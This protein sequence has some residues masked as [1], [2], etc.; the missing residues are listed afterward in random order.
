MG[1]SLPP[2]YFPLT[3]LLSIHIQILLIL[4]ALL[5]PLLQLT[6]LLF[7]QPQPLPQPH[8]FLIRLTLRRPHRLQLLF[9]RRHFGIAVALL[10]H[11]RIPP[12][13][14][15]RLIFRHGRQTGL[16]P[17]AATGR[18]GGAGGGRDRELV[19]DLFAADPRVGVGEC[20]FQETGD[21]ADEEFLCGGA[22]GD[23]EAGRFLW[24]ESEWDTYDST[25]WGVV[26]LQLERNGSTPHLPNSN[27]SS[28]SSRMYIPSQL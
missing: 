4:P 14:R 24:G 9:Q 17:A 1:L 25:T 22:V 15:R 3:R 13:H 10:R 21:G 16:G 19:T 6:R 12:L 26:A 23:G 28:I 11:G 8:H 20:E 2:D 5:Q 18:E 7:P 27:P